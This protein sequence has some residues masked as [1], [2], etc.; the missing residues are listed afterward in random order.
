MFALPIVSL[1]FLIR[2]DYLN[3]VIGA[4]IFQLF[5]MLDGCDGEIARAKYLESKRGGLVDDICDIIG[6]FLFMLGLGFGLAHAHH[7]A[8]YALEAVLFVGVTAAN[9]ALLRMPR[10]TVKVQ[11]TEITQAIYPRHRELIERSGVLLLGEKFVW[12]AV[13]IQK[14]DVLV[15]SFLLLALANVAPWILHVALI[16]AVIGLLLTS[17]ARIKSRSGERGALAQPKS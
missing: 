5:S 2:G 7:T 8:L 10:R 14:R 1:L 13:Q 11:S 17:T 4:A 6:G 3:L 16:F 15:F 12:W 9:E